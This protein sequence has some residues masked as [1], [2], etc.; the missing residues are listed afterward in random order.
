MSRENIDLGSYVMQCGQLGYLQTLQCYPILAGDSLTVQGKNLMRLSPLKRAMSVDAVVD[1]FAFYIPYRHVYGDA[2]V[3]LIEEGMAG[4]TTLDTITTGASGYF[5][6]GF[7]FGAS[8]TVA[9][10]ILTNQWRIWNRYFRMPLVTPEIPDTYTGTG[11]PVGHVFGTNSPILGNNHNTVYGLNCARLK[12]PWT[13]GI[14]SNIVDSMHEVAAVTELDLIDLAKQ[15][16]EFGTEVERNWYAQ[17]YNDVM[18]NS[19]GTTVNTDADE[20]PEILAH[21]TVT[22]SGY[23]VDGSSDATLGTFSGKGISGHGFGFPRKNFREHGAVYIMC[24][25]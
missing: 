23:D 25:P 9:K 24:Q 3:T 19:F 13:T 7:S 5:A 14:T 22:I 10:W 8:K 2:W 17:R 18:K 15:K 4:A 21:K 1:Y 20:R 11:V 6:G 16:V 12:T